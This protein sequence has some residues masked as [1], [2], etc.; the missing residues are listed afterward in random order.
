M[1]PPTPR[2]PKGEVFQWYFDSPHQLPSEVKRL[3]HDDP[4]SYTFENSLIFYITMTLDI[5]SN[6]GVPDKFF[7]RTFYFTI[8]TSKEQ[9]LTLKN[10]ENI[11]LQKLRNTDT[12]TLSS[13][14]TKC[15]FT[16]SHTHRFQSEWCETCNGQLYRADQFLSILPV[17]I[18]F[19]DIDPVTILYTHIRDLPINWE[20]PNHID[21]ILNLLN[22][23]RKTKETLPSER[24]KVEKQLEYVKEKRKQ[25][26]ENEKYLETVLAMEPYVKEKKQKLEE[27][28][29]AKA[30]IKKELEKAQ[31]TLRKQGNEL[32]K[33]IENI[34][35]QIKGLREKE[36]ENLEKL[37]KLK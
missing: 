7:H 10:F 33:Q 17:W 23:F 5:S 26:D 12:F 29:K 37:R 13:Y 24:D 14:V 15:D 27:K 3:L 1:E 16:H 34:K 22:I 8:A 20:L 2:I 18:S 36:M 9:K 6:S 11:K 35:D 28:K 32:E 21:G 19:N 31:E 25:I 30:E 4:S